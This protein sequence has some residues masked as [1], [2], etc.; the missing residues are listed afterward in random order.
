MLTGVDLS[1]QGLL[2]TAFAADGT[3]LGTAG[4]ST[5]APFGVPITFGALTETRLIRSVQVFEPL[6][7]G[8]AAGGALFDNLVLDTASGL[9]PTPEPATLLLFASGLAI[10]GARKFRKRI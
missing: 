4:Y 10:A 5:G 9:A 2:L 3:R 7:I 8:G 1:H 6:N